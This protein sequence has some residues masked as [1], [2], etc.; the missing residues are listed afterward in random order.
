MFRLPVQAGLLLALLTLVVEAAPP[1]P[2]WIWGT[3][4]AP[5]ELRFFRRV[6]ELNARPRKVAL[7]I[8]CD[9]QAV[10]SVNDQAVGR[11]EDWKSP[12][13]LNLTRFLTPGPNTVSV[14]AQNRSDAAGLLARLELTLSDGSVHFLVTDPGWETSTDGATDWTPAHDL[15]AHGIQPWGAVLKSPQATPAESL[16]TLPGFQVELIRSADVG[17]G[18]WISMAFDPKGRLWISPQGAEPLLRATLT[19]GHVASLQPFPTPARAAMGLLWAFDSLYVNGRGTNGTALYRLR[20]LDGNDTFDTCDTLQVWKGEGGEHGPH[21]IASDGSHLF[22]INGNFVSVPTNVAPTSPV[23]SYADDVVLP[24]MEDGNGFATGRKPPGGFIVRMKPDG[25]EPEL[26]SAG[27]RNAYDLAFNEDGELFTF[28]S[29][30]EGDWGLPWYRPNRI[31]HCFAGTDHGFR[32]GSAKWPAYYADSMGS[33]VD[34]GLGSPTGLTFGSGT[35]FPST[36]Q[37]ALFAMDWSFGRILAFHLQPNGATYTASFEPFIQ[38]RPLNVTDLA[39]GPDGALY[40]VT[41]GRGIQSGL[42]RVSWNGPAPATSPA[43]ASPSPARQLRTQLTHLARTESADVIDKAWPHLGSSDPA[44]RYAARL[45][46]ERQPAAT[47]KDRALAET[48]A[49]A[50]L[51]ALLALARLGADA[52]QPALL[53]AL[54]RWPLDSLNEELFLLKLRTIE[55]S[56]AR[57]GLPDES[58][59]K[60][61]I[62]KLGRQFPGRSLPINRELSQ[63]LVAFGAP[64]VVARSLDLRDSAPNQAEAIHYQAVLRLARDGWNTSLRQRYLAWFHRRPKAPF[65]AAYI[66]WFR[67]V[68][69]EP[70][71]GASFDGFLRTIRQQAVAS[72]PDSD[73]GEL[74]GWITGAAVTNSPTIASTLPAPPARPPRGHVQSWKMADLQDR[75]ATAKGNSAKGRAVYEEAQCA[76]CHRLG[77]EGGA[78]GPDLTGAGARYSPVDLL[79]SLLEP[80]AVVSEQFQ[81]TVLTLKDGESV[82]GRITGESATAV[83]LLVDPINGRSHDFPKSNIQSRS[84]SAVS[85]MPEGLLDTFTA[86]E[87]LDLLAFLT[88]P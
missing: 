67:Q 17:E 7:T 77:S 86:D 82:S 4:A 42:Y 41:G 56:V 68:G 88:H 24:R 39:V 25:S 32:E 51:T 54:G 74:A 47:W 27:Q 38:G 66:P 26:F 31:L 10:V 84:P 60:L 16:K 22:A 28:D 30:M 13:T 50:G 12:T 43:A 14:L 57:H 46:I 19:N 73:K 58:L 35:K 34:A 87:I 37:K 65:P 81:A 59:R 75:L 72:L 48:N 64:E 49:P 76:T 79:R 71:N 8:A 33:V 15:G 53:K 1:V 44:I 70:S 36:Y 29:D 78:V 20:D 52:D 9:D 69:L 62:D 2:H 45:A 3:N 40:F 85:P 6:I 23:R 21:G 63:L 83:S 55:V 11:T 5:N 61:A 18:S 80:S